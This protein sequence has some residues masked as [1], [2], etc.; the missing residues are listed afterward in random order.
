LMASPKTPKRIIQKTSSLRL[1]GNSLSSQT[2]LVA[3][4]SQAE[5]EARRQDSLEK[6]LIPI[7]N[8]SISQLIPT[9]LGTDHSDILTARGSQV[10]LVKI[11]QDSIAAIQRNDT[12]SLRALLLKSNFAAQASEDGILP[13]MI[14]SQEG[15]AKC[16]ST[17]V[18]FKA[19]VNAVNTDG[20]NPLC[21][22]AERG[23]LDCIRVLVDLKCNVNTS[24]PDGRTPLFLVAERGHVG[25]IST[26]VELK[27]DLHAPD[28]KGCTP[29]MIASNKSNWESINLLVELKANLTSSH[30]L[31][32]EE[33][34]HLQREVLRLQ[35][36]C[37]AADYSRAHTQQ[38][39][40]EEKKNSARLQI[41]LTEGAK[42]TS[43]IEFET[44]QRKLEEEQKISQKLQKLLMES[45]GASSHVPPPVLIPGSSRTNFILKDGEHDTNTSLEIE[46]VIVTPMGNRK[47]SAK[48]KVASKA[49][50]TL[51][52]PRPNK[53]SNE[54][55]ALIA[56]RLKEETLKRELQLSTSELRQSRAKITQLTKKVEA[57]HLEIENLQLKLDEKEKISQRL[58]KLLTKNVSPKSHMPPPLT[59]EDTAMSILEG[60]HN[61]NILSETDNISDADFTS[62]HSV[63]FKVTKTASPARSKCSNENTA[64][65]TRLREDTLKR[66]LQLK[67]SDLS[68]SKDKISMLTKELD[69]KRDEIKSLKR[70]N[71]RLIREHEE[72]RQLEYRI[73]VLTSEL[74]L[75][76]DELRDSRDKIFECMKRFDS[77]NR[78]MTAQHSEL[79][80]K[81]QASIDELSSLKQQRAQLLHELSLQQRIANT[82]ESVP[83]AET[84]MKRHLISRVISLVEE[85]KSISFK[86]NELLSASENLSEICNQRNELLAEVESLKKQLTSNRQEL[87]KANFFLDVVSSQH[88]AAVES[89]D[90]ASNAMQQLSDAQM[91]LQQLSQ[92]AIDMLLRFEC[93]DGA[94]TEASI[95][96]KVLATTEEFRTLFDD[97]ASKYESLCSKHNAFIQLLEA[98][99]SQQALTLAELNQTK[100]CLSILSA[101]HEQSSAFN[102]QLLYQVDDLKNQVNSIDTQLTTSNALKERFSTEE[103]AHK[104]TLLALEALVSEHR[105]FAPSD[106]QDST[107]LESELRKVLMTYETENRTL[108]LEHNTLRQTQDDMNLKHASTSAELKQTKLLLS[109]LAD[110]HEQ[111]NAQLTSS[112]HYL[113]K[114]QNS[115]DFKSQLDLL[116]CQ[117]D[118]LTREH[119]SC[120]PAY[121]SL[122]AQYNLSL[123]DLAE[124]RSQ[125]CEVDREIKSF[126]SY[127]LYATRSDPSLVNYV[128]SHCKTKFGNGVCIEG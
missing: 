79:V 55:S 86:Y 110:Q 54:K 10:G 39:L 7:R 47:P 68:H 48:G 72:P 95:T 19:S 109:V 32:F 38:Q 29:I 67:F 53:S 17:L 120:R 43:A 58:Q 81:L 27:S 37:N 115:T 75:S 61:F 70:A 20:W 33:K 3:T 100:S 104:S 124:S 23:Q 117:L 89:K 56:S 52:S 97:L 83:V 106:G 11:Q 1:L 57:Q 64:N 82:S 107:N 31:P 9:A 93:A 49:Y 125:L 45:V 50:P 35:A 94:S 6:S 2:E 111:L 119:M 76:Q 5:R 13:I 46:K 30:E 88:K 22:A 62:K 59:I 4:T 128:G 118:C 36:L 42:S 123:S 14:A 24:L 74:A 44:L 18:E 113:S 98:E 126:A 60:E 108:K 114:P 69:S 66:E 91:Q 103:K 12:I 116:C 96:I 87:D 92:E 105:T 101:Q 80:I 102:T 85:N 63:K 99:R 90:R 78:Q 21:L 41:L 16:I 73:E 51:L 77:Q 34:V 26:L 8:G 84:E 122:L 28:N 121:D 127:Y 112:K 40:V 15:R 65:V 71:K 25:C